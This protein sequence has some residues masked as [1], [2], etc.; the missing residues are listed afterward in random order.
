[1]LGTGCFSGFWGYSSEKDKVPAVLEFVSFAVKVA[2]F[3]VS[4]NNTTAVNIAPKT[5]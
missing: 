5:V 4:N 2:C 1:M 3:V